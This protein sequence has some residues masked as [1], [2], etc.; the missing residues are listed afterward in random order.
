[1][2]VLDFCCLMLLSSFIESPCTGFWETQHLA[3]SYRLERLDIIIPH[4]D[5]RMF[6]SRDINSDLGYAYLGKGQRN[7]DRR[8]QMHKTAITLFTKDILPERTLLQAVRSE[9]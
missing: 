9:M 8:V 2:A 1:M 5:S 4:C 3:V 6:P 7:S